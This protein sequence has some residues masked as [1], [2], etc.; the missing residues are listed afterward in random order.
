MTHVIPDPRFANIQSLAP[1][2]FEEVHGRIGKSMERAIQMLRD[3]GLAEDVAALLCVDPLRAESAFRDELYRL[4]CT[5]LSAAFE[6]VDS[7][8]PSSL[9]IAGT[10]TD[11]WTR[12]PAMHSR[13][14]V[15]S[16]STGRAIAR[17]AVRARV[18][19]RQKLGLN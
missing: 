2:S 16:H 1:D 14:L 11:G 4:G 18:L 3:Q 8:T 5:V 12:P 15:R 17:Q 13:S 9:E 7:D 6:H 19:S 10:A